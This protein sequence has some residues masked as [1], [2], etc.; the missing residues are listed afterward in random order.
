MPT[1]IESKRSLS[2][3]AIS[4]CL[5]L[6]TL[7]SC[8]GSSAK[9][10]DSISTA[11]TLSPG[12]IQ[13][14]ECVSTL[15]GM[16]DDAIN[17]MIQSPTG[18]DQMLNTLMMRYG[19]QSQTFQSFLKIFSTISQRVGSIGTANASAEAL[20]L[21][22]LECN[23]LHP[24]STTTTVSSTTTTRKDTSSGKSVSTPQTPALLSNKC[25]TGEIRAGTQVVEC[26]I[27]AWRSNQLQTLPQ[28]LIATMAQSELSAIAAPAAIQAIDCVELETQTANP[29][30]GGSSTNA[31]IACTFQIN[32]SQTLTITLVTLGASL[33][34]YVSKALIS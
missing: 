4:L 32:G 25:T 33:G 29:A 34:S 8:G 9:T 6:V 17:A 3:I 13:N 27:G 24:G 2:V 10:N 23:R 14:E 26:V 28:A 22:K 12:Q 18:S 16:I 19:S 30:F 31:D 1:S 5:A 15:A 21:I 11:T 20:N 7:G